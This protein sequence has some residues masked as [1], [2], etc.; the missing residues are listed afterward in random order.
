Y[1]F[2]VLSV[3]LDLAARVRRCL[4][5]T[6]CHR[7]NF[8]ETSKLPVN[9]NCERDKKRTRREERIEEKAPL[10]RA[11]AGRSLRYVWV[12]RASRGHHKLNRGDW[13][14]LSDPNAESRNI[15]DFDSYGANDGFYYSLVMGLATK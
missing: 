15:G 2:I 11:L 6:D 14:K 5:I 7:E 3:F 9:R 4:F 10:A 1:P 13:A 12:D 8:R